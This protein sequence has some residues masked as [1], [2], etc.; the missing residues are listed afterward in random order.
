VNFGN[1]TGS[2]G[3]S[4]RIKRNSRGRQKSIKPRSG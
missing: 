1:L 3:H 4:S 2:I